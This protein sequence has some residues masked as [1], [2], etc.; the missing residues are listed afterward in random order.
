MLYASQSSLGEDLGTRSPARKKHDLD[1]GVASKKD[2]WAARRA[3]A[4]E[5]AT[6]LDARDARKGVLAPADKES[7]AKL[8]MVLIAPACKD[9]T[10]RRCRSRGKDTPIS[11]FEMSLP[12]AISMTTRPVA[13]N[14]PLTVPCPKDRAATC[15]L[16]SWPEQ[17]L[18][19]EKRMRQNNLLFKKPIGESPWL[20]ERALLELEALYISEKADT[21]YTKAERTRAQKEVVN[22]VGSAAPAT[23]GEI[24]PEGFAALLEKL[25]A[26]PGQRLYDLGSG[27][28][29]M[30]VL[31]WLLGF[32]ATGVELVKDRHDVA[33]KI[34]TVVQGTKEDGIDFIHGDMTKVDISDADIVF[35]NSVMYP[36]FL[37]DRIARQA[38]KMR[39]GTYL[40]TVGGCMSPYLRQVAEFKSATSWNS[41]G[42]KFVIQTVLSD[43]DP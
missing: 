37:M 34:Q 35:A 14:R 20:I 27:T 39:P 42:A 28:G 24:L 5:L 31:A 25:K 30:V 8:P 15:Q 2:A 1:A 19:S 13:P 29:K 33:H 26:M 41:K 22:Q 7:R 21:H 18:P 36:H 10:L 17:R 12:P 6:A 4:L 3:R 16:R 40:V 38:E 32:N 23:Y 43:P 9:V 11:S